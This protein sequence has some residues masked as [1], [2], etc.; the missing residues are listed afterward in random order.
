MTGNPSNTGSWRV[1]D[2]LNRTTA[3]L[4]DRRIESPRASAEILL[5]HVL[6]LERIDLYVRFDQPVTPEELARFREAVVRR[7]KG[8]PA[9]YIVGVKEFFGIP[10]SVSP[11]VLIPRPETEHLVDAALQR[12][13]HVRE[14]SGAGIRVLDLGTGSGAIAVALAAHAPDATVFASDMSAAALEIAR[15]NAVRQGLDHRIEW[16]C[17]AWFSPFKEAGRP[18]HMIV[19]NPPYVP[20]QAIAGL[21]PEIAFEPRQA[22]DGGPDGL[23][24]VRHILF[25]AGAFLTPGGVLLVEIGFDQKSAVTALAGTCRM[26]REPVFIRDYSGHDRVVCLEKR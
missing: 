21:Q 22:L 16:V 5:A 7:G 12:L 1:L 11:D 13:A 8:E 20:S 25:N 6:K 26:Y 2:L 3:Y 4:K 24:A 18:F 23:A 17:G 9:A 14:K 19:S 10:F 15:Q